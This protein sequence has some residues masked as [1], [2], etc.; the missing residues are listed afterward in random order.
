MLDVERWTLDVWFLVLGE[1]AS[2]HTSSICLDDPSPLRDAPRTCISAAR[3]R[4]D[5]R[6]RRSFRARPRRSKLKSI[7][8]YWVEIDLRQ[9]SRVDTVRLVQRRLCQA[10]VQHS[11][12]DTA[13]PTT[14][15]LG[16]NRRSVGEDA[17]LQNQFSKTSRAGRAGVEDRK[18]TRLNSSH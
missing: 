15:D 6:S 11:A 17:P 10:P 16:G 12:S 7:C 3:A 4:F 18:S 5:P 13:A 14:L 1:Q 9:N 2:S 8:A